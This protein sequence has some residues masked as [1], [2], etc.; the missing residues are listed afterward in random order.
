MEVK[1]H[2]ENKPLYY[3]GS[4]QHSENLDSDANNNEPFEITEEIR[5]NISGNP[6]VNNHTE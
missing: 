4:V 2:M 3:N 5:K 1:L 6:Y